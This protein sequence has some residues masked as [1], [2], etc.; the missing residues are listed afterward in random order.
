MHYLHR[1]AASSGAPVDAAHYATTD[2]IVGGDPTLIHRFSSRQENNGISLA[3]DR[4]LWSC[5]IA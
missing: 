1:R 4:F 3:V 5:P 2:S